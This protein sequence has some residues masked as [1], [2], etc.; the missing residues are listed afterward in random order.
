MSDE[1]K[2]RITARRLDIQKGKTFPGLSANVDPETVPTWY[3]P[4]AFKHAQKL[5]ETYAVM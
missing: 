2:Q 3:D 4:I 1:L 5:F